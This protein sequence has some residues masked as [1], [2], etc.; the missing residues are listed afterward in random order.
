VRE[1]K[2]FQK[3]GIKE[4]EEKTVRFT[5][6][7]ADLAY[8]DDTGKPVIEPGTFHVFV[9]GSSAAELKGSFEIKAE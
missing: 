4:A 6:K 5:L 2:G 9:G 1:V 8:H 3:M 7:A